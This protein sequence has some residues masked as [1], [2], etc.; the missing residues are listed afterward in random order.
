MP[1]SWEIS[2]W[3][4]K[5]YSSCSQRFKIRGLHFANLNFTKLST[6]LSIA[7][8]FSFVIFNPVSEEDAPLRE[9]S[10]EVTVTQP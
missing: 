7:E 2:H 1:K 6:K 10:L 8:E 5:K 3:Q 4:H 9:F